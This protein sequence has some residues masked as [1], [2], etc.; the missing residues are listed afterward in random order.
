MRRILLALTLVGAVDLALSASW[1]PVVTVLTDSMA[2]AVE[3]GDAVLLARTD[4]VHV[5][6]I[7]R[8]R[9]PAEG[10]RLGYPG[11]VVHRVVAA[12]PDGTFRIQGDAKTEADPFPV[13]PGD[14]DGRVVQTIPGVGRAFAT[15]ASPFVV[16]WLALGALLAVVL[17]MLEQ[18]WHR[19]AL[20]VS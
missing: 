14:I 2:P 7:V 12:E 19:E 9:V 13:A 11:T 1:P 5:G 18:R 20:T 10:R 8:V 16:V 6:D 3:A 17:P 15:L 4:R